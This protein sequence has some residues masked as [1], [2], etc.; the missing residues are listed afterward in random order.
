LGLET[1]LFETGAGIR[2]VGLAGVTYLGI[3]EDGFSR[4]VASLVEAQ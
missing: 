1:N 2:D 3:D 4:H